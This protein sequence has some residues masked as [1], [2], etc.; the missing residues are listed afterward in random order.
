VEYQLLNQHCQW[1]IKNSWPFN[2]Y[3]NNCSCT[4][5]SQNQGRA[6]GAGANGAT[7][8]GIRGKG[9]SKE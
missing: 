9:A 7:A 8:P 2:V 4:V 3:V 1:V 5:L 6:V